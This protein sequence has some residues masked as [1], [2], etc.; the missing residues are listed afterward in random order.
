M[1][2][3]AVMVSSMT[4][5]EFLALL[6]AHSE[7]FAKAVANDEGQWIIKGFID[8]YRQIYTVSVDTKIVSKVL[9]L[10]LFPMFVDFA[11]KHNLKIELC[12]H[13]N[14]YPD[15]TFIH[16]D[17]AA[18][19]AV[20]IKSTYRI[21]ENKANG[22]T[23]GAF[24]GYFRNRDSNKNTLYP[25]SQYAAHF[26]LGVVY[27]Q[28]EEELDERSVYSLDD[29]DKIPSVIRNFQFFAQPKFRIASAR[30][31]SGNT[32]NIGSVNKIADLIMGNGPFAVLGEEVYDD[33]WMY[34]LTK[35]MAQTAGISRPYTNLKTYAEYKQRGIDA[36]RVNREVIESLPDGGDGSEDEGES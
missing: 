7:G 19:F 13:Q 17:T 12:P 30:P 21:D 18:R 15:L 20:D 14:F 35:D 5:D 25:Y 29:L 8:I 4:T 22:M 24:T 6:Q 33:Y 34:Y 27:S 2:E 10:L 28:I 26:V 1:N 16:V 23:L 9:E 3:F 32:K 36:L 11:K 31:G